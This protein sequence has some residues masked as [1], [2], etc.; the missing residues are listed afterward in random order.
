[1]E[2][3]EIIRNECRY[4]QAV[5]GGFEDWDDL[6]QY[7]TETALIH[8]KLLAEEK[9]LDRIDKVMRWAMMNGWV[10]VTDHP[11]G[12]WNNAELTKKATDAELY[13]LFKSQSE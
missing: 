6:Y 13:E 1:M 11:S 12:N 7:A 3:K 2:L 4:W 5:N 9:A 8:A 10:L